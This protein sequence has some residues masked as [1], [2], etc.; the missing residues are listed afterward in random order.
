MAT[1]PLLPPSTPRDEGGALVARES[2]TEQR[3]QR[4]TRVLPIQRP[5]RS[6]RSPRSPRRRDASP[7]GK[8]GPIL[9]ALFRAPIAL[10]RLRLGWLLGH[11]FLLLT[12]LGRKSGRTYHTALECIG[13]DPRR[14][15]SVVIAGFG[16]QSDWYRNI[17]AHPA[18]EISTGRMR[19]APIQRFLSVEEG[20]AALA[21]YESRN[22]KLATSGLS[23]LFGYDGTPEGRL[24]LAQRRPMVAFRPPAPEMAPT[25]P[26]EHTATQGE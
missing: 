22:G 4:V 9:R 14:R 19:Y 2:P 23:S 1:T 8:P 16:A 7:L 11:R 26:T 24:A 6:P 21:Y 5:P 17:E 3:P 10:Y 13:Y 18:L 15:E 12:H 25:E 20:A